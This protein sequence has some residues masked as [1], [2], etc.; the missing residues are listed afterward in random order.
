MSTRTATD[1]SLSTE[2]A[3]NAPRVRVWDLPSRVF[4]WS[5]AACFAGAWLTSDSERLRDLH[6][7]LGYTFA[8]LLAFRVLWGLIGTRYARFASFTFAPRALMSYLRSLLQLRPE[9][10]PGHNPAGAVAIFGMLGL[11]LLIAVSGYATW[12]EIGGE[13]LEDLHEGAASVML[14]VVGI[15]LAGVLVSSLLHGENLAA[16]MFSGMKR[17]SASEGIRRPQR[18][19]G[20]LLLAS[21]IGFWGAWMSG[22]LDATNPL[23]LGTGVAASSAHHD[24]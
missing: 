7:M 11:G 6:V 15:H 21:V 10:H 19:V 2:R 23:A 14:A 20:I 13:W 12:Q 16:A 9:H 8:G 17:G 18:I 4:H 3:D 24:D 5:F 22:A 1:T